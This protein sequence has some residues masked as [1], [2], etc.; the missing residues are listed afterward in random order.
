MKKDIII[1]GV[2]GQGILT[3][4][5]IIDTAAMLEGL[6]VKQAEVHG[7]SQRGGDVQSHLRISSNE[8][9]SD[10]IPK[11]K[12]DLI[13]AVEPLESLRYIEYLSP[14]GTI[15][16]AGD[17][18]KNIP[19]YPEE[20]LIIKKL[21]SLNAKVVNAAYLAKEAGSSRASNVV[22]LGAMSRFTDIPEQRFIEAIREMFKSKGENIIE[23]NLKAFAIGVDATK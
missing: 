14:E 3:I 6:N 22:I 4:A 17:F 11:G 15:V 19:N 23:M 9:F 12:C 10:L 20:E 7:M 1:A 13:V 21:N 16:T 2:G 8:I 5:S 18:F